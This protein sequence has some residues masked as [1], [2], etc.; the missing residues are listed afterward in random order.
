ML[1]IIIIMIF[2]NNKTKFSEQLYIQRRYTYNQQKYL[3][4]S[5]T[6]ITIKNSNYIL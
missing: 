1:I 2:K 4:F 5:R 3:L 6:Q